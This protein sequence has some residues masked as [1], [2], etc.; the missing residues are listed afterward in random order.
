MQ[1][2]VLLI[3]V[4]ILSLPTLVSAQLATS[5]AQPFKLGTFE[6]DG[7]ACIGI[8]L[9]DE[10]IVELNAANAVLER[11]PAYPTIPMPADMRELIGRYEYGMKLRLYEIVNDIVANNR[12]APS[13]R[14]SLRGI[15][16]IWSGPWLS[17]FAVPVRRK[18]CLSSAYQSARTSRYWW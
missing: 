8:V 5:S 17:E 12:M 10:L 6:I 14:P 3:A 2:S 7:E 4:A 1:R 9:G 13:R 18:P 11:S 15:I 16:A